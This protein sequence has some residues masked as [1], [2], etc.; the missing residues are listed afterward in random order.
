ARPVTPVGIAAELLASVVGRLDGG[1]VDPDVLADLARAHS[2]VAGLDDYVARCTSPASPALVALEERTRAEPWGDGPLEQEMLSG[3]VEGAFLRMLVAVTGAR[4]VLEIGMFTG[5]SALAMAEAMPDGSRLVACEVDE[6]A[7]A[8]AREAFAASS[9]GAVV[10]VRVGPAAET[11]YRLA[12]DGESFD[13]V[14]LDADKAGYA[15]YLDRLLD[16]D[17]LAPDGVVVVDNTLLQGEPWAPASGTP[18]PPGAAI[19]DFNA[20]VAADDRVEQVLLPLR[21]GVTLIRRVA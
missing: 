21:D 7:V 14:F 6:R 13:L 16:L 4:R 18:T 12:L 10:D 20:R 11:L 5:Y 2:L 15:A 17:L 3:H 19:A 1:T 9:R 8:I